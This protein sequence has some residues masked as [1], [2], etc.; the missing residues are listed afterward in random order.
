MIFSFV[1]ADD[2]KPEGSCRLDGNEYVQV[3][4]TGG[5]WAGVC[6]DDMEDKGDLKNQAMV[7]CKCIH[8]SSFNGQAVPLEQDN[9]C[10]YGP[11]GI[12]S[13]KCKGTEDNFQ[14]CENSDK[15]FN[16]KDCDHRLRVACIKGNGNIIMF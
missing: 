16:A 8:G 7:A 9:K 11:T 6:L 12:D 3:K 4:M 2:N 5:L 10:D 13:P 1:Y 14:K 15:K